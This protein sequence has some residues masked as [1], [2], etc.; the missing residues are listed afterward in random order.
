MSR[1][2]E[3]KAILPETSEHRVVMLQIRP[4]GLA[5]RLHKAN[6]PSVP[7]QDLMRRDRPLTHGG[8]PINA[9]DR[10]IDLAENKVDHAIQNVL[11]IPHVVV[12]GHRLDPKSLAEL[13]HAERFDAV[14]IGEADGGAPDPVPA[15]GRSRL[16]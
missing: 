1:C 15:Q 5:A 11:L 9:A 3:R 7:Q 10:L 2:F 13:A 12:E 6:R 8:P 14:S 4:T 16:P